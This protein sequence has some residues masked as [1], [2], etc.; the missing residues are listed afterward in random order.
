MGQD[1]D[2]DSDRDLNPLSFIEI[3]PLVSGLNEAH[4][5]NNWAREKVI[6]KT[7]DLFSELHTPQTECDPS[8]KA[9]VAP[10][11]GSS[12]RVTAA[13]GETHRTDIVGRLRRWEA[14]DMRCLVFIGWVISWANEEEN[15][16]N[17]FG[18]GADTSRNLGHCPLWGLLWLASELPW[19]LWVWHSAYANVL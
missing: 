15:Y 13:M 6:G 1:S 3:E 12:W 5:R 8:P 10:G 11:Q 4:R 19:H 2:S 16:S 17:Y 9:T 7:M 14:P 18:E